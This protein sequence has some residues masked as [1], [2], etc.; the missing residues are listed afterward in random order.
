MFL[1][2]IKKSFSKESILKFTLFLSLISYQNII[3]ANNKNDSIIEPPSLDYLYQKSNSDYL[4]GPGD[5]LDFVISRALLDLNVIRTINGNGEIILPKINRVYVQGL[6][7][8]ELTNLLNKRFEEY[9]KFPSVEINIVR[10]RPVSF[11]LLGEIERPG[12]YTLPGSNSFSL[13]SIK[14]NV[15]DA[16]TTESNIPLIDISNADFSNDIRN[17]FFPTI[18]DAIKVGNGITS[19]SDLTKVEV[20]RNN[21]LS[22]G[23][24]LITTKL[25]LLTMLKEGDTSQNIRLLDGDTIKIKKSNLLLTEQINDAIR[26][27]INPRFIRV[28]VTGKV[29]YPGYKIVPRSSSLNDAVIVAGGPRVI[30]GPINLIRYKSDGT[31]ESKIIRYKSKSKRG[32]KYNPFLKSGDIV[33]INKN[34]INSSTEL[35]EEVTRP[36]IGIFAAKEVIDKF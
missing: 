14:P 8:E 19:F 20:I 6:T 9:I 33:N 1:K 22:K 34:I 27:N 36:F 7:L 12:L 23:G 11:Y 30:R 35:L 24:G 10:Y 21:S 29:N 2:K 18:F 32:S 15:T 16:T 28:L 3:F 25:N 31:I 17:S 4:L 26:S 13:S 5:S